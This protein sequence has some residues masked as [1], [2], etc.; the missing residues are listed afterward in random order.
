MSD[1]IVAALVLP[2]AA[3]VTGPGSAHRRRVSGLR[4][5]PPRLAPVRTRSSVYGVSAVDDRGRVMAQYVFGCLGWPPGTQLD[6]R[7]LD[8][9]V[10]ATPDPLAIVRLT[11]AGDLRLPA[12]L[13]HWYGLDAGSRVFLAAD[14]DRQRLVLYPP[15]V[16]DVMISRSFPALFDGEI[17]D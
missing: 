1:A 14:V 7:E 11:A 4:M 9:L 13:R 6:L 2:K 3:R 15:A 16:L 5:T 12:P 17:H 10:V 8:G